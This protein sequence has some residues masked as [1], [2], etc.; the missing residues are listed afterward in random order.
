MKRLL[1]LLL[2]LTT[3][4]HAQEQLVSSV[5]TEEQKEPCLQTIT[6]QVRDQMTNEL[7]PNTVVSLRDKNGNPIQTL[8]ATEKATFTFKV[9]CG[10]T[11]KITASKE[12]YNPQSKVFTTSDDSGIK[13]QTKILLDQ[14]R[15]D[16]IYDPAKETKTAD[17]SETA[18]QF[19]VES[20]E[21]VKPIKA[22]LLALE[23][24][25]EIKTEEKT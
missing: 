2:L 21:L 7:I 20:S 14:G 6:G 22:N 9:E 3:T 8:M 16:F 4:V 10:S 12:S 11:Y 24:K 18:T 1:I 25:K 13:L 5:E 19:K 17:I 23:D 15:I